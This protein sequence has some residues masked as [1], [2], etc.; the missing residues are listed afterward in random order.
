M[1]KKRE[2]VNKMAKAQADILEREKKK[3]KARRER[4]C[5]R[6]CHWKFCRRKSARDIHEEWMTNRAAGGESARGYKRKR[7]KRYQREGD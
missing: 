5:E 6:H 2:G 1:K 7:E 3:L 4:K